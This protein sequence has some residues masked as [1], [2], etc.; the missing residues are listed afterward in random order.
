[1]STDVEICNRALG[2]IGHTQLIQTLADSNVEAEQC[3]LNFD[4]CRDEALQFHAWNF[5]TK[6]VVL[7]ELTLVERTDWEYVYTYP[8][9]CL[10]ARFIVPPGVRNPMAIERIEF[11]IEANDAGDGRVILTDQEDAELVYTMRHTAP[12]VWPETFASALAWRIAVEL[13]LGVKKDPAM[14]ERIT[15]GYDRTILKAAA[16]DANEGQGPMPATTPSIAAR[17]R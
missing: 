10:F 11:K 9:D 1:M 15:T 7:A 6:R 14:A 8:S 17:R 16:T 12:T 4:A 2:R 5:A 3:D 13:A